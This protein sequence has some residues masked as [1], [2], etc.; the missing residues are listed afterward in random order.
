MAR[1]LNTTINNWTTKSAGAQQAFVDGVNNTTVDPTQRAIANQSGLLSGFNNAVNSGYWARRLAAV[2]KAGWQSKT[3]A[4]AS[5]YGTGIAAGK[6]AYSAA[7]STW[8]PIID[9]T[10]AQAKNMPGGSLGNN[11]ARA[12]YFATQLYNRKRG[13]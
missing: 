3:I 4:K 1:D 5:N 2:G 9:Q 10:A 11:L 6:D 7:M 13:L 12:N 8:L